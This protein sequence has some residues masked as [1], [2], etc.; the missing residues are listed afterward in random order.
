MRSSPVAQTFAYEILKI[1]VEGDDLAVLR[2][3]RRSIELFSPLILTEFSTAPEGQ[4]SNDRAALQRFCRERAYE[5][6]GYAYPAR[7]PTPRFVLRRMDG[8]GAWTT[9]MLFLVPPRLHAAFA[10]RAPLIA[11]P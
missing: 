1:D 7:K 4:T 9:K 3:S 8:N 2:G 6:W 11:H 5:I 10:A